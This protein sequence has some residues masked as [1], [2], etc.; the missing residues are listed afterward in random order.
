MPNPVPGRSWRSIRVTPATVAIVCAAVAVFVFGP[1]LLAQI[2][3]VRRVTEMA[4][5]VPIGGAALY[6]LWMQPRRL[7]NPLIAFAV[8]KLA[9]EIFWR[10]NL[11]YVSEGCASV[12][13]LIVVW[14]A[15]GRAV[16]TG[17]QVVVGLATILATMGLVEWVLLFIHPAWGTGI[18]FS[19][20]G[21]V[22]AGFAHPIT[23]LGL[24]LQQAWT[25]LGRPVVRLQSFAREPSL[26]LVFFCL[27]AC[28]ALYLGRRTAL[29]D[30]GLMLAFA[31]LSFSGSVYLSLAFGVV[32]WILGRALRVQLIL[33]WAILALTTV[34]LFAIMTV[35]VGWL[36]DASASLK[37]VSTLLVKSASITTRA[38]PAIT[39]FQIALV[40]PLG[41]PVLS[42]DAGPLY[43]NAG[44]AAGWP[45]LVLLTAFFAALG[46]LMDERWRA[47]PQP[48]FEAAT[49]VLLGALTTIVCFSDY[50]MTTYP[51]LILLMFL[52][53]II[54]QGPVVE[55]RREGARRLVWSLRQSIP[56]TTPA[57]E[58][59]MSSCAKLF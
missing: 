28:L 58:A 11:L 1:F 40:S 44:L 54:R 24:F 32:W 15:G 26:N 39:K 42:A 19:P 13:G 37:S 14:C 56:I 35:G 48:S 6:Y 53:R 41:S 27:P 45:G 18:P 4:L 29:R 10:S 2:L 57:N 9:L 51:G 36:L 43:V 3:G 59:S 8:V 17:A 22:Q 47:C 49:F 55:P 52:F 38:I 5:L 21:P 7:L 30:A 12:A 23:L 25:F 33:P 50:A 20:E 31:V 34:Y 46:R 16:R